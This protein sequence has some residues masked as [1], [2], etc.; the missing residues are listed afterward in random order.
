VADSK[1][2]LSDAEANL[3]TALVGAV[4]AI[5]RAIA[6]ALDGEPEAVRRVRDILPERGAS[7]AVAEEL[8][9]HGA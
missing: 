6:S 2:I 3:L 8:A 4:P 7:Q 5:G 1:P 9:S